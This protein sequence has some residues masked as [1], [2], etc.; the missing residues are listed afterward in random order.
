MEEI[1]KVI[2]MPKKVSNPR[3]SH[4]DGQYA[5]EARSEDY[6]SLRDHFA[7]L[8]MQAMISRQDKREGWS[9]ESSTQAYFIADEMLKV[10][11]L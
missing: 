9:S 11:E 3:M 10:R 5:S 6:F 1:K 8:A 4:P 7:G 2:E